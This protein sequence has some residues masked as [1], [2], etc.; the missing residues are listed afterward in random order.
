MGKKKGYNT[1]PKGY[2][3][4]RLKALVAKVKKKYAEYLRAYEN[5]R[6]VEYI[7]IRSSQFRVDKWRHRINSW[8]EIND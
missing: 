2:R 7:R 8:R 1:K 6:L 5:G 3:E 4:R